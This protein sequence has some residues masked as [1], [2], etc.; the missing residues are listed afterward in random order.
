MPEPFELTACEAADQ[1][2]NRQL[3]PVTLIESLLSRA[4]AKE[5]SLKVW[6]T[7]DPDAALEAARNSELELTEKGPRGPLHGVPVGIKDIFYTKGVKT[8]AGSPIYA[9]FVPDFDATVVARLK[10]AGAIIMGKTVTTQFACNDPPPTRNPWN[11]AHTPG[12][13]SSGSAVGVSSRIFPVA[14]GTQTAGSILRPASY[15]GVV[16]LKPTFG[17][18]SRYGV[19]PVAWSLDTIGVFSRTVEDAALMLNVLA[20]HDPSDFSSSTRPVSDY[21]N[22]AISRESAPR[23]GLVR[24]FFYD[25]S[26][27]E[28]SRQTDSAARRLEAAGAVIDEVTLS[29]DLDTLLSAHRVILTVELA[30]VHQMN[31][32]ARPDDYAPMVRSLIEAGTLTPAV[33][34]VQAQRIRRR[35]RRDM[36]D[37]IRVFD[38]LLAPSTSSPAP[39]DLSTTGNPMFQ[40]PWTTC[41]FPAITIPSGLS[42]SGMPLGIQLASAPFQEETLLDAA[43]W[44]EQT[45]DVHRAPPDPI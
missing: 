8:T 11:A 26:D 30:A 6:V 34:Y 3:S 35:F 7:L 45:L 15:N 24:Q 22:A 4:A 14:L 10:R 5:P 21:R 33:T 36:E 9:D 39:R 42:E 32:S 27:D 12:G 37:A 16:G 2:R 23:I 44:C 25:R 31:F 17:R 13:S 40:T 43:R 28:V 18:I 19:V 1:I 29:T 41:G 38:V 20:G